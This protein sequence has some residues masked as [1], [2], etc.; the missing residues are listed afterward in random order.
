VHSVKA[1]LLGRML[2]THCV[3]AV[4]THSAGSSAV[5]VAT[6]GVA[7]VASEIEGAAVAMAS[8][9]SSYAVA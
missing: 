4:A 6:S 3:V 8:T 2:A 5:M 9:T 1:V 7:A